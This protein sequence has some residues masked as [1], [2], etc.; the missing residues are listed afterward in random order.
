MKKEIL[1][2]AVSNRPLS[3]V[4]FLGFMLFFV[5]PNAVF[6]QSISSEAPPTSIST[7]L[8]ADNNWKSPTN[9]AA[10]VA[11]ER[12]IAA[13]KLGAPSIKVAEKALFTGYDRMLAFM[14]TD[15]A[16]NAPIADIAANNFKRVNLQVPNDALLQPMQ[17]VDFNALYASLI[18]K[19]SPQ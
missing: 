19:L 13:Q 17:V 4:Y 11:A 14:Q 12:V 18:S 5:C 1:H 3:M 8:Y 6:G 9:Y 15:L 2:L 7:E 10:V 16:A